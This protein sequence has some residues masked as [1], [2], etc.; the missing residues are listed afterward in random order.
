MLRLEGTFGG[1]AEVVS[2][3][4]R[5]LGELHADVIEVKASDFFVEL[6]W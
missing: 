3:F 5:K 1:D 6:L 2:L 4:L